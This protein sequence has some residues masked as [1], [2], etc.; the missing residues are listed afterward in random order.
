[1][2]WHLQG[3]SLCRDCG[4]QRYT[5]APCNYPG[6]V[7]FWGTL[8]VFTFFR[9]LLFVTFISSI[10]SRIRQMLTQAGTGLSSHSLNTTLCHK[11]PVL[12]LLKVTVVWYWTMAFGNQHRKI[13]RWKQCASVCLQFWNRSTQFAQK[14]IL[15]V[16]AFWHIHKL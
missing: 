4:R 2:L 3:S 5:C 14:I 11:T 8:L 10:F 1:M 13:H 9:L 6:L 16:E 15:S 7:H 12:R